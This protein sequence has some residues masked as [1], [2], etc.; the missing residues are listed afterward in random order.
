MTELWDIILS[1]YG[2]ALYV[3]FWVL[4]LMFGGWVIGKMIAFLP[5]KARRKTQVT[6]A[7]L[8]LRGRNRAA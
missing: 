6:L 1:P 3:G 4:K 7:R 2:L 8:G 5:V